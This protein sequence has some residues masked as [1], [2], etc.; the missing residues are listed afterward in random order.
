MDEMKRVFNLTDDDLTLKL[1]S[2]RSLD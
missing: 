1:G 2:V